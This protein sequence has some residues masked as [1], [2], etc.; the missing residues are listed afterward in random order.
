MELCEANLEHHIRGS[1]EGPTPGTMIEMMEQVTLGLKYLHVN[2]ILHGDLK[3]QNILI[4]IPNGSKPKMKLADFGHCMQMDDKGET[5]IPWRG[6]SSLGWQ[7]PEAYCEYERSFIISYPLDVFSLGC[8]FGYSFTGGSHP[9]GSPIYR[10]YNIFENRLDWKN[11][12]DVTAP[13]KQMVKKMV[14]F[15]PCNRPSLDCILNLLQR[16]TLLES[17]LNNKET[18]DHPIKQN[19]RIEMDKHKGRPSLNVV[20]QDQK[21]LSESVEQESLTDSIH[22]LIQEVDKKR[23][24]YSHRG[25]ITVPGKRK[26]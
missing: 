15:E 25:G 10:K 19:G 9:F 6:P 3:P 2:K 16:Q 23:D 18:S 17:N 21:N 12:D 24:S 5:I 22:S 1:Y 7:P 14:Q 8:V 20:T 4:S 26:F 13:L 11:E